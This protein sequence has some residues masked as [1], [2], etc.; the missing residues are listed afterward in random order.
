MTVNEHERYDRQ[1]RLWGKDGQKKLEESTITIVGDGP[2]ARDTAMSLTALGVGQIRLIGNSVVTGRF[3]GVDVS[4]STVKVYEH[5]LKMINPNVDIIPIEASLES[6]TMEYFFERSNL[7]IDATNDP[8]S[9]A[10]AANFGNKADFPVISASSSPG[11]AK[12]VLH[13]EENP[14][15]TLMADF[16]GFTQDD[17]IS[18]GLGGI[19][20]EE[21][22]KIIL[23]QKKH[24]LDK[25]VYYNLSGERFSHKKPDNNSPRINR[26]L[27]KGLRAAVVGAGALA[28]IACI[29]LAKIGF[30]RVDYYDYDTVESHNLTR[31]INFFDC[32]GK[33]KAEALA[34]K[35]R[36][37]NPEADARGV[38][39]KFEIK[40]GIYSIEQLNPDGYDVLFDL[41]DNMYTRAMLGT[42]AVLKGIPLVSAAS[43]P[44]ASEW[45][46]YVPGKTPCL[47][48]LFAGY[49]KRGLEEEKIRRRSCTQDPNPAVIMTNQ[50]A[51]AFSV[52]EALTIFQPEEFGQP[53]SGSFKY[54]TRKDPRLSSRRIKDSCD[55]HLTKNVPDMEITEEMIKKEVME[56]AKEAPQPTP[57]RRERATNIQEITIDK[58]DYTINEL[59]YK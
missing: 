52:L 11:Y 34:L 32:V 40:N 2:I 47:E 4:G 39:E 41:V 24:Y 46:V 48:H 27:Y 38:C 15:D 25:P 3:L 7:I 33:P 21:V 37:M 49:Y 6:R 18:L 45:L 10:I 43:S 22:K 1:I 57:R 17:L 14:A 29:L 36:L 58:Q 5:V 42:Y 9:K 20:A 51:G 56:K 54:D 35:H 26:E 13:N 23:K 31:Q 28:N 30:G 53:F 55:C 12:L 59:N 8:R 16:E 19:I 44:E 50:V